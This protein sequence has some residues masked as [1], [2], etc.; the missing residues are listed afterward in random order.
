[1]AISLLIM[2]AGQV[3]AGCNLP[4]IKGTWGISM[5]GQAG[6]LPINAQCTMTVPSVPGNSAQAPVTGGCLDLMSGYYSA[7]L[8]GSYVAFQN[9][10]CQLY[11]QFNADVAVSIAPGSAILGALNDALAGTVANNKKSMHGNWYSLTPVP[12]WWTESG[13]SSTGIEAFSGTFV[14][15]KGQVLQP[16]QA[17]LANPLSF[18]LW[19][20][21]VPSNTVSPGGKNGNG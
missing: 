11:G 5:S 12:L 21:T 3:E 10:T 2:S 4:N 8:P 1:M 14:G 20:Y 6:G 16:L 17:Y 9:K 19:P 15:V 13:L 18:T 7:F